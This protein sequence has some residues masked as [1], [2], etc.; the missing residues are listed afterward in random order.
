MDKE[1][2][3]KLKEVIN[4]LEENDNLLLISNNTCC[5]IGNLRD[6]F[7]N[8]IIA[9]FKEEAIKELIEAIK[10]LERGNKNEK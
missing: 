4:N 9:S 10:K 1:T 6:I 2:K 8:V 7:K 3:N 5:V